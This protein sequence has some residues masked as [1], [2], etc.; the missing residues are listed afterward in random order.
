MFWLP[1]TCFPFA[2]RGRPTGFT[3]RRSQRPNAIASITTSRITTARTKTE[4]TTPTMRILD[5]PPNRVPH[6]LPFSRR[7]GRRR[8]GPRRASAHACCSARSDHPGATFRAQ[9]TLLTRVGGALG[10]E[11]VVLIDRSAA[12]L[13]CWLVQAVDSA[14]GASCVREQDRIEYDASLDVVGGDSVRRR[15]ERVRDLATVEPRALDA[16]GSSCLIHKV[17]SSSERDRSW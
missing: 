14:S 6:S 2:L 3:E 16:E 11:D 12:V 7:G 10:D 8:A 5:A 4:M 13:T 1:T 15:L 17:G 9:L